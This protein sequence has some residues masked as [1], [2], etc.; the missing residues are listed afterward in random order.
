MS[1][2]LDLE[3]LPPNFLVNDRVAAPLVGTT[4]GMLR[5]WR[6]QGRG[7]RYTRIHNSVRYRAVDL[8]DFVKAG[9]VTP[10]SEVPR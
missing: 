8:L 6:S 3:S 7:P 9:L 4:R 1:E 2:Q 5:N 10:G